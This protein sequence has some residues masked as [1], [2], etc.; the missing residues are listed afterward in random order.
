MRDVTA[1]I[2]RLSVGDYKAHKRLTFGRKILQI[3]SNGIKF[4]FF[5]IK[6]TFSAAWGRCDHCLPAATWVMMAGI[7]DP[8]NRNL[9]VHPINH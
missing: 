1:P 6:L 8:L 7:P 5:L 4:Q 3:K 9:L 2:G